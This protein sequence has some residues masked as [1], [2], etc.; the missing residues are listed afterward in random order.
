MRRK[1]RVK[2]EHLQTGGGAKDGD[3]GASADE[4]ALGVGG[5]G[6]RC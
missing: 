2:L 4:E 3:G 5:E 1:R 6:R